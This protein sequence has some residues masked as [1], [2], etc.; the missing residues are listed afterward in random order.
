M[1]FVAFRISVVGSFLKNAF[2]GRFLWMVTCLFAIDC[3]KICYSAL[4]T[5][6]FIKTSK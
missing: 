3:S 5:Q 1:D 6:L 2:L 4:Q